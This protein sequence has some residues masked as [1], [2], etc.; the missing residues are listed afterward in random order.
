MQVPVEAATFF[1]PVQGQP[2]APVQRL[3]RPAQVQARQAE[4]HQHQGAGAGDL[5]TAL[6]HCQ[7]AVQLQHQVEKA[8]AIGLTLIGAGVGIDITQL[9]TALA[10]WR[11]KENPCGG[12]AVHAH[13]Q[14]G[15]LLALGGFDPAHQLGRWQYAAVEFFDLEHRRVEQVQ[16]LV[17]KRHRG[18]GYP[19]QG[20]NQPGGY[21]EKPV[22][23]KQ[24]FLKHDDRL[25]CS[26]E[27]IT[28]QYAVY[29]SSTRFR[30]CSR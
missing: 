29:V 10:W 17:L 3:A 28:A 25:A 8:L 11:G 9:A 19:H 12:A 26:I 27:F 16:Q 4:E 1:R 5:A 23:L 22:Q 18:T 13:P 30:I 6:A 2:G 20:Q 15:D 21:A 7:E 14:H 24:C